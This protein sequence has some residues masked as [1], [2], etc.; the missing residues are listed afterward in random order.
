RVANVDDAVLWIDK[1]EGVLLHP[2]MRDP[3]EI[4]DMVKPTIHSGPAK[5]GK[6]RATDEPAQLKQL[7]SR[8]YPVDVSQGQAS[9]IGQPL[10][11][12]LVGGGDIRTEA[13]IGIIQERL[14]PILAQRKLLVDVAEKAL[15]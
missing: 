3:V 13:P 15:D 4:A 12:L 14:C 6:A 7:W 9:A 10:H 11:L 5:G 2:S 8:V 1:E